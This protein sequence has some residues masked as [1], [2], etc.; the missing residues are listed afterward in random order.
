ME[1]KGI[2]RPSTYATIMAKLTDKKR[3]YLAKDKKYLVPNP[4]SYS[5]IDFLVKHFANIMNVSFTANMEDMLDDIG[6]GGKD[7]HKLT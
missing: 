3:E 1:D 6:H 7:W 2:G 5:L 4:I